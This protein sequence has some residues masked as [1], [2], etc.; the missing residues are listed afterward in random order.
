[1][2]DWWQG[3]NTYLQFEFF[4]ILLHKSANSIEKRQ[5]IRR[6]W[7]VSPLSKNVL[8]PLFNYIA[9]S[10]NKVW[11]LLRWIRA[12]TGLPLEVLVWVNWQSLI[13]WVRP[14]YS[15]S[16]VTSTA[17][18]AWLT[19]QMAGIL[20]QVEMTPRSVEGHMFV[21]IAKEP[22]DSHVVFHSCISLFVLLFFQEFHP[23]IVL[24]VKFHLLAMR[25][26][27]LPFL[28]CIFFRNHL[29]FVYICLFSIMTFQM[30][31]WDVTDSFCFFTFTE[32]TGP[33]T[34]VVFNNKSRAVLS[35]SLDGTVRAVDLI[36]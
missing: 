6:K 22:I 31:L 17:W 28:L 15:N 4:I 8:W 34:S 11:L 30:K 7:W 3:Q 13:G 23:L 27:K 10:Q 5:S 14:L 1:M 19:H 29:F 32:H 20:R 25:G 36:K 16:K 35:S 21:C 24:E 2:I 9:G 26:N 33:V 12:V 18:G